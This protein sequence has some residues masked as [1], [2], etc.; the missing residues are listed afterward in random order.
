MLVVALCDANVLYPNTLRDFL[1]RLGLERVIQV[2]T[3]EQILD[4]AFGNLETNRP[5]LEPA[6]FKRT[7]ELMVRAMPDLL[8]TGYQDR[9]DQLS[10]P[11]PDDRHVL[12][13]AIAAEAEIIVTSN[14]KDFPASVLAPLGIGAQSPDDFL[15]G[16]HD[17]AAF[18]M[19]SVVT[20]IAAAWRSPD[21][22]VA[23]VLDSLAIQTPRAVELMRTTLRHLA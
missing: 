15:S 1:L 6:R 2:R 20:D 18:E 23:G 21:A 17:F 7:R 11:D 13:A 10:L 9:I 12:A 14:L 22:T 5:D 3:T 19:V 8:V 16:L 4:E